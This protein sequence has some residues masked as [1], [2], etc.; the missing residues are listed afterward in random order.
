VKYSIPTRAILQA[1]PVETPSLVFHVKRFSLL[2]VFE[3]V[4]AKFK[5]LLPSLGS[6]FKYNTNAGGLA[7]LAVVRCAARVFSGFP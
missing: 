5:G 2:K 7:T 3:V 4:V 6:I 1:P